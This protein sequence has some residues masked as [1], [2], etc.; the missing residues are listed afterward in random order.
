VDRDGDADLLTTFRDQL[1]FRHVYLH[2]NSKTGLLAQVE[3]TTT[4]TTGHLSVND[5]NGDG[6]P[7]F[8]L[9]ASVPRL[10]QNQQNS[11]FIQVTNTLP[12]GGWSTATW[13]DLDNDGKQDVILTAGGGTAA[14]RN[15]GDGQFAQMPAPL[16]SVSGAAISLADADRDGDL[17]FLLSDREHYNASQ[18]LCRNQA[19]NS[20]TPPSPPTGLWVERQPAG[21]VLR[22]NAATDSETPAAALTYNVRLGTTPGGSEV[23]SALAAADTGR[24]RT[25]GPGNA[26]A[27]LL[28]LNHLPRGPLYWSAQSVDSAYAG[29]AFASEQMYQTNPP[30]LSSIPNLTLPPSQTT[31]PIPF[32]VADPQTPR[33][34]LQWN[35]ISYNEALLPASNVVVSIVSTGAVLHLTPVRH[36]SGSAQIVLTVTDQQGEWSGI[37]V[38]VTVPEEFTLTQTNFP[39]LVRGDAAWADY[40]HDGDLDL[41]TSGFSGW[42]FFTGSGR[43]D[44]WRN[45]GGILNTNPVFDFADGGAGAVRFADA[46]CD[47]DLDFAACGGTNFTR[48]FW[49]T[50]P[51]SFSAAPANWFAGANRAAMAWGDRD[52]DGDPELVVSGNIANQ[53]IANSRAWLYVNQNP[54]GFSSTTLLTTGLRDGSAEWIDVDNDGDNDLFLTGS[55]T[56]NPSGSQTLLYLNNSGVLT[57]VATGLPGVTDSA[58]VFADFDNDGDPDL[59][60]C[61]R[62]FG[63]ALYQNNGLGQFTPAQTNLPAYAFGNLAAADFD[64]DSDPDLLISGVGP[65]DYRTELWHNEGGLLLPTGNHFNGKAARGLAW[66]DF[67]QDGDLDLVLVGSPDDGYSPPRIPYFTGLFRNDLNLSPP[68]LPA[69]QQLAA[70]VAGANVSL[71]WSMPTTAPTGVSYNVRVGTSPFAGNIMSAPADALTG[72]LRMPARGN[73][74]W[75][76]SWQLRNLS[77]GIYYWSVQAVGAAF[78][79]AP[80]A[81]VTSFT[82]PPS[83]PQPP[84]IT[85]FS[86]STNGNLQLTASGQANRYVFLEMSDDLKTWNL[87]DT[88]QFNGTGQINWSGTATTSNAFFRLRQP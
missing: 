23:V 55:T 41:L 16:P 10:F 26:T 43:T 48:L 21:L 62:N 84:N 20:N 58:H 59:V 36:Q 14:F 82:I 18:W 80:F 63:M 12:P 57:P 5:Y 61:G 47:G 73:A 40:D 42:P 32:E 50:S 8:L 34:L 25:V 3:I 65:Q 56:Y 49:Q 87:R 7:D 27:L 70:V 1:G 67:D 68:A 15:L 45:D 75:S 52:G 9:L 19:V 88:L 11:T 31:G 71:A 17:D 69:P 28:P 53:L 81:P 66:G 30:S 39:Q 44:L 54:S 24:K 46:D 86:V 51:G 85:S 33:E 4:D 60:L 77:N 13:G 74:G 72:R 22:W 79:N 64:N 38:T 29:S 6:W 35:V 78:Q 2:A 83:T 37:R 76:R